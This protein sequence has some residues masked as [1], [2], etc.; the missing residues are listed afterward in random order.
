MRLSLVLFHIGLNQ[1]LRCRNTL[2]SCRTKSGQTTR[3]PQRPFSLTRATFLGCFVTL[4]SNHSQMLAVGVFFLCGGPRHLGLLR[5]TRVGLLI[6]APCVQGQP[7]CQFRRSAP[8]CSGRRQPLRCSNSRQ[9]TLNIYCLRHPN[10]VQIFDAFPESC[11]PGK[12]LGFMA[13]KSETRTS[14][15]TATLDQAAVYQDQFKDT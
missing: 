9:R 13:V 12:L 10:V 11:Q 8:V 14:V 15:D 6:A 7:T 1:S 3:D 2:D 5:R 4:G